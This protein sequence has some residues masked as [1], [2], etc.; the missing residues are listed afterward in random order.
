METFVLYCKLS[1][2]TSF[3][4][5]RP[6]LCIRHTV[7]AWQTFNDYYNAE[8]AR[9]LKLWKEI[10]GFR[11]DF[12]DLKLGTERDL[13]RVRSEMARLARQTADACSTV[14]VSGGASSEQTQQAAPGSVPA[15]RKQ[16]SQ[17]SGGS[18]PQ[19]AGLPG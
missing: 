1:S 2:P 13:T 10:V 16:V 18:C 9:M 15:V 12:S 6:V 8:H 5:L 17:V 11:R 19:T 4:Q 7:S 3:V 14:N